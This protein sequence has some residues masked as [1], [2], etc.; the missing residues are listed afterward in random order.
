M[1]IPTLQDEEEFLKLRSDSKQIWNI[2]CSGRML[3]G[4]LG[5]GLVIREVKN[6]G[7]VGK[8]GSQGF[9]IQARACT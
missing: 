5:L 2:D 8:G 6:K 1:A 7:F 9:G 4:G 3:Y